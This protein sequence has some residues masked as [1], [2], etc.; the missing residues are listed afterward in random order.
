MS[1]SL[2]PTH[3]TT[4]T[5]LILTRVANVTLAF[6]TTWVSEIFQADRKQ[7]L[8]MPFYSALVL[9]VL[10]HNSQVVPLIVGDRLLG[11]S[12]TPLKE[13][14]TIIQLSRAA[15]AL[16]GVGIIVEQLLG[17]NQASEMDIE[18]PADE[19]AMSA[20]SQTILFKTDLIPDAL[21]QPQRWRMP[22]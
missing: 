18:E 21:W 12:G 8:P 4:A 17:S 15:S 1:T 11:N 6:P 14:L 7:V 20:K 2:L 3:G 13:T 22:S 19:T 5:R 16:A 9:G 10:H